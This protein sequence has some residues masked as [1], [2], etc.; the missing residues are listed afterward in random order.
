MLLLQ[1]F[2]FDLLTTIWVAILLVIL[3]FWLPSL[4]FVFPNT[5]PWASRIV[6][7]STRMLLLTLIGVGILNFLHLFSW[8][9]LVILY[10]VCFLLS[11][12]HRHDWRVK[13][14]CSLIF[15][16]I[17]FAVLD[18]LD[19]SF[20]TKI[21]QALDAIGQ[22]AKKQFL[23]IQKVIA[24]AI[25]QNIQDVL[26][27]AIILTFAVLVRFEYPLPELRFTNPDSYSLLLTTRQ[28]L[29]GD[30]NAQMQSFPAF[31]A[32]AAVLS[33][34]GAID[35][36]QVIRFLSPLLGCLLV[37]SVGY[38][39]GVIAPSRIAVMG[40][41]YS[42]G[43]YVF[44]SHIEIPN[45]AP[46]WV[47]QW[48]TTVTGGLNTSLIRQWA[49]GDLEI[50]VMCLVLGLGRAWEA[51][52]TKHR[53]IALIDTVC[54]LMIV[55]IIQPQLLIL[56]LCG[57]ISFIGG[58]RFALTV[59]SIIWIVLALF[60][61]LPENAWGSTNTFLVTLPVGLSWLWGLLLTLTSWLLSLILGL[62]SEIVSLILML[63]IAINFLLPLPPKISYL[64]YDMAARKTLELRIRFPLKRWLIVAP[65]EQLAE[66]Y[67]AGWYEDMG[68]FVEKYSS[69]VSK[70]NF[71]FRYSVPNLFIFVEK[72]P[73][74][75][76]LGESQ[77]LP[78]SVL[79]DPTYRY[80]RSSAGRASLQFTMLQM[81][82]TYRHLHEKD[83]AIYYE[84][85]DLRIYQVQLPEEL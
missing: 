25:T 47:Q 75:T 18:A 67:G 82:E 39:I 48:L 30:G 31:S 37:L 11:W 59:V 20:L 53:R 80:Y 23:H 6:A 51:S 64:E 58:G 17:A 35:A 81:C 79:S 76:G 16:G 85:Q 77:S 74:V 56:A 5:M 52:R 65:I 13:Q 78:Y 32:L 38:T 83:V 7:G 42:L 36:M 34:L 70:P 12:L 73:L 55:A 28:I 19:Q 1:T 68:L 33:L 40:A 71:H 9:T 50:G 62:W 29:A 8:L 4:I 43:A 66:S 45:F 69:L 41:M 46:N 57:G 14:Q 10:G 63:A 61:A 60:L 15:Q 2:I 24:I 72:R 3:F 84:D 44:T 21:S 22:I 54:C 26:L 49:G 27:L